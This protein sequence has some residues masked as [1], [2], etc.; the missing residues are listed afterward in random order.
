MTG[1]VIVEPAS[2]DGEEVL[3]RL[4][5]ALLDRERHFLGLAVA[6]A[7]AAVAVADHD[8]RGE[9]EPT[10]ALHDLGDAVDV[11]D[12]R[13]AQ[14]GVTRVAGVALLALAVSLFTLVC[15]QNSSPFSRAASATRRDPAVVQEAAAVEHDLGRSPAA[16]ARSATSAPTCAGRVLVAGGLRAQSASSVDAAASVRPLTSSITC[17]V[18]CLFERNTAR[19]GRS[20]V[21]RT[22]LRT[23]CAGSVPAEASGDSRRPP[24]CM[25][26]HWRAA[27]WWR[28]ITCLPC[29]PCA[30]R[31]RRA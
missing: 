4:F 8:E 2:G 21:P 14:V 29:R 10:T 17:A 6:E 28:S 1:W 25:R 30:G 11:D 23:R 31:A 18:M 19:R 27:R 7:D 24:A 20:A 16:L 3:A 9:A 15:H 26:C 12:P 22:F 13:L 5:G